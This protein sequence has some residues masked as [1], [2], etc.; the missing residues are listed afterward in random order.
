MSEQ[1]R[2][3]VITKLKEIKHINSNDDIITGKLVHSIVVRGNH[4]GLALDCNDATT[5]EK[6][7]S[8]KEQCENTLLSLDEVEKVTISFAPI[9]SNA[10]TTAPQEKKQQAPQNASKLPPIVIAIGAGKGGVGKSTLTMLIAYAL[11]NAGVKVAVADADIYGPSIPLM[12]GTPSNSKPALDD[13]GK[14]VP[15]ENHGIRAHSIGFL[16]GEGEATVWRGPMATK[17]LYQLLFG[18]N[19]QD[20]EVLLIDLPPG[21]GD[22]QLSIANQVPLSAAILVSTPQ[23]VA[24]ADVKKAASMYQKLSVPVLGVVENMS[25]LTMAGSDEK[26]YLFGQNNIAPFAKEQNIPYLGEIPLIPEIREALDT[27]KSLS[28]WLNNIPATQVIVEKILHLRQKS[29]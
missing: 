3:K 6:L 24:L 11:K 13:T 15:L 8:I 7:R 12:L 21:T 16:T 2:S 4:V 22:I 29:V 27:G 28:P 26:Q 23:K 9:A 14:M 17:A 19:W 1:I 25:Y 10:A 5:A 18:T 20:S